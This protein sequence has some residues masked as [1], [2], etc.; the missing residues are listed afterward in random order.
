MY[1]NNRDAYRQTFIIAWQKHLKKLPL[2]T[3]E[4]Q[5][6]EII[7]KHPEYHSLLDEKT[8]GEQEFALDENPFFHMSL[9][10]ALREQVHTNRP[11]GIAT[12]YQQL[13]TKYSDAH[14]VEH[15]MMTCL[16]QIMW[17]A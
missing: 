12:L 11:N 9:H 2:E 4:A 7:L 3:I 5:L 10:L 6:I 13:I 17:K 14:D 1:S 16:A 8:S 15:R